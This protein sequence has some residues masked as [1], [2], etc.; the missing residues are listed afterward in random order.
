VREINTI[1][2]ITHNNS[3]PNQLIDKIIQNNMTHKPQTATTTNHLKEK[4]KLGHLYL[5]RPRSPPVHQCFKK[6]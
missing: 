5:Y 2:N 4:E 3:F 6:T 1:W